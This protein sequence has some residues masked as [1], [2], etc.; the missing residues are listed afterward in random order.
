MKSCHI[1]YQMIGRQHQHQ[2]VRVVTRQ[3]QGRDGNGWRGVAANRFEHDRFGLNADLTHLFGN[4][5]AV[6]GVAD[7]QRLRHFRHVGK[8]G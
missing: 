1:A 4:H 2:G 6:F 8:T 3:H 7:H 5:E